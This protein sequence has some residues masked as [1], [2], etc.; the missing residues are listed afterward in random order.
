[1]RVWITDTTWYHTLISGQHVRKIS[2]FWQSNF[3]LPKAFMLMPDPVKERW[4][5]LCEQGAREQDSAKLVELLREINDLFEAKRANL[6]TAGKI[7]P[8]E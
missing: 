6:K 3:E 7:A 2:I 8:Q 5:T 1:V 4:Q